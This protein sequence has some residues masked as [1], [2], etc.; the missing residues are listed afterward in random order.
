MTRSWQKISFGLAIALAL[1]AGSGTPMRAAAGR[2][3]AQRARLDATLRRVVDDPSAGSQRVIVR[4]KS[5][6]SAAVRQRLATHGDR[7]L[8]E[9]NSID[10]L[11]AVV[12]RED[13]TDLAASD[14]VLS[15]SA[16][17]VVRPNGL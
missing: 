7:I 3:S 13:L 12:H 11:T 16:D 9:H 14:D 1:F 5:E 15:V 2:V 8:T 17:A 4:F 6:Q 10:A